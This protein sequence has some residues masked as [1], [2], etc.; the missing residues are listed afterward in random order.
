[1]FINTG[2]AGLNDENILHHKNEFNFH[3]KRLGV[4]FDT[5]RQI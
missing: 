4:D 3:H 2:Y 1:M 5:K